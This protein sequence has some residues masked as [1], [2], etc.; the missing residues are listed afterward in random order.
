MKIK[1]R[2]RNTVEVHL[3]VLFAKTDSDVL[4]F[5]LFLFGRFLSLY[6]LQ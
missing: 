3:S 6:C 5:N 4:A 2:V 1:N